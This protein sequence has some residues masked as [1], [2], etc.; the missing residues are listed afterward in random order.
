MDINAAPSISTRQRTR[1]RL[2][3]VQEAAAHRLP[4]FSFEIGLTVVADHRP[5]IQGNLR[6]KIGITGKIPLNPRQVKVR[7]VRPGARIDRRTTEDKNRLAGCLRSPDPLL[8]R[9]HTMATRT[10]GIIRLA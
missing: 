7:A 3:I 8:D 2:A 9:S 5:R 6:R 4:T 10:H 1:R